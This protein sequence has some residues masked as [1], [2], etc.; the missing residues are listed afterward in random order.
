[1]IKEAGSGSVKDGL[2]NS[3]VNM[4]FFLPL[5]TYQNFILMG[6]L[7]QRFPMLTWVFSVLFINLKV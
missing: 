5:K 1:M 7:R 2:I 3:P 6:I 4:F